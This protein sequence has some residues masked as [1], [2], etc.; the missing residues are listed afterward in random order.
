MARW[1]LTYVLQDGT[2]MSGYEPAPT[3]TLD[4]EL[5]SE[6]QEEQTL[7]EMMR[8]EVRRHAGEATVL[9][10]AEEITG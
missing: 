6:G 1:R 10:D 9:T 8:A 3:H 4:V 5:D 2:G 7:L